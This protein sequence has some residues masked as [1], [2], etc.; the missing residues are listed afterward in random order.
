MLPRGRCVTHVRKGRDFE[1]ALKHWVD[2]AVYA[3]LVDH[4]PGR[5]RSELEV[6]YLERGTDLGLLDELQDRKHLESLIFKQLAE[7]TLLSSAIDDASDPSHPRGLVHPS[8]YDS[9]DVRYDQHRRTLTA[10]GRTLRNVEI[11]EPNEIPTN[12]TR[13]P[14][15]L[16]QYS[17][18]LPNGC[19][20][21]G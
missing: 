1:A 5:E 3:A 7:G 11:F 10:A 14:D 17:D 15:W 8:L 6:F 19:S 16:S 13:L 18:Q 12:V 9:D 2:P 20:F 21:D 4:K